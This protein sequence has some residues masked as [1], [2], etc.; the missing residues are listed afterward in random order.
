MFLRNE[1]LEGDLGE[2]GLVNDLGVFGLWLL[3]W[4]L[5]LLGTEQ[6]VEEIEVLQ[7]RVEEPVEEG[8]DWVLGVDGF[9][10][11]PNLEVILGLWFVEEFSQCWWC[12]FS[13]VIF[14]SL[15][16]GIDVQNAFLQPV[17]IFTLV[18]LIDF[19]WVLFLGIE[20]EEWMI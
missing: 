15:S 2:L 11:K 8:W 9:E 16:L 4:S 13:V 6:V 10:K 14:G 12:F 20:G 18:W 19:K 1:K 5:G 17:T 3:H 7:R